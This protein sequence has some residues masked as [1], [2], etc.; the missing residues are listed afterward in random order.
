MKLTTLIVILT[1]SLSA[2][3]AH[4]QAGTPSQVMNPWGDPVG[5]EPCAEHPEDAD[6]VCMNLYAIYCHMYRNY[7]HGCASD[8]DPE[9]CREHAWDWYMFQIDNIDCGNERKIE[10][11]RYVPLIGVL[12]LETQMLILEL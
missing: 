12:P 10:L 4:V 7:W 1:L 11:R 9:E 3:A 2:F 6:P 5:P 8:P